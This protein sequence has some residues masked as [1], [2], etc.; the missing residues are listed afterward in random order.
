MLACSLPVSQREPTEGTG[1]T[2]RSAAAPVEFDFSENELNPTQ[3]AELDHTRSRAT[4]SMVLGWI[5]IGA[6][7]VMWVA[8]IYLRWAIWSL[9]T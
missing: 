1:R 9:F 7:L 5:V 6:W 8:S 3:R 4:T 2:G